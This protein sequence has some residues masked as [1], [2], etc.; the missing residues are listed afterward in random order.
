MTTP[1]RFRVTVDI[2]VT[3]AESETQAR[4]AAFVLLA[5]QA[6]AAKGRPTSGPKASVTSVM[7]PTQLPDASQWRTRSYEEIE[8]DK[9]TDAME[10]K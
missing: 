2:D 3:N 8:Q 5:S 1:Y 7:I 9:I 4:Q 10:S 6:S